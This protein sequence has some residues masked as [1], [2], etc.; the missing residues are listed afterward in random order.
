MKKSAGR[1]PERLQTALGIVISVWLVSAS[2]VL[3]PLHGKLIPYTELELVANLS[4]RTF[5]IGGGIGLV[6]TV[7][8]LKLGRRILPICLGAGVLYTATLL[9]TAELP[10]MLGLCALWLVIIYYMWPSGAEKNSISAAHTVKNNPQPDTGN[11][12]A[13]A[14]GIADNALLSANR[15][16]SDRDPGQIGTTYRMKPLHV[17]LIVAI[18]TAQILIM[19]TI[20]VSRVRGFFTP[21]FDHGI[22]SQIFH[23]MKTVGSQVT[24]LERSYPLS[25]FAVHISPILYLLVPFY[26][27]APNPETLQVLQILVVASGVIPLNLIMRKH[28]FHPN[29]RVFF[30]ALYAFLPAL[31][32]S[33]MYDFHEN[34]CLAPLL[35]WLF[36]AIERKNLAGLIVSGIL[37]L[38]VKED[39]SYYLL[40]IGL[41]LPFESREKIGSLM[42]IIA[43]VSFA[44]K[45]YLISTQ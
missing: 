30:S 12:S 9:A 26:A 27:L 40:L 41:W 24:T 20:M 18:A 34:C 28:A 42:M 39:A 13:C 7:L 4:W 43:L 19:S 8:L 37:L 11:A 14:E 35:L 15:K 23:Q 3:L 2:A 17:A 25:H 38:S 1:L 22:F 32:G 5:F 16:D 29:L 44:L 6:A 33:N 10:L 31:N 36:Y 21:S 45:A